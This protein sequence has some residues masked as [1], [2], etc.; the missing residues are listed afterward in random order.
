MYFFVLS[1]SFYLILI[2]TLTPSRKTQ[3][4][5]S[6]KNASNKPLYEPNEDGTQNKVFISK[7]YDATSHFEST[8]D[9]VLD[10][11]RR[12]TGKEL[13]MKIEREEEQ[14]KWI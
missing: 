10:M 5:W 1:P 11:Y 6:N 14:E 12:I 9:A 2:P 8:V 3:L 13:G 4:Q 7:S